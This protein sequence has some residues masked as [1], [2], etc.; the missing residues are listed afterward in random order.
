MLS[1]LAF[2]HVGSQLVRSAQC[3]VQLTKGD[4]IFLPSIFIKTPNFSDKSSKSK[5]CAS[6]SYDQIKNEPNLLD[7]MPKKSESFDI[8]I[9]SANFE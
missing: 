1:I 7:F 5:N 8:F 6:K 3:S 9:N 4:L 2:A